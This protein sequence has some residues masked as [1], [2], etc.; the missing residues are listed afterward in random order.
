MKPTL[1]KI[2]FG[3]PLRGPQKGIFDSV[4]F[5]WEATQPDY[6]NPGGQREKPHFA[7]LVLDLNGW[8]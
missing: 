1:S 2:P 6:L 8:V 5:I 7:F 4:G 3:G